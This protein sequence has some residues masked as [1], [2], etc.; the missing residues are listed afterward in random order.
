MFPYRQLYP[1]LVQSI[2]EAP[3]FDHYRL[4][5]PRNH[6]V[7]DCSHDTGEIIE[8]PGACYEVWN[9]QTPCINCSSKTCRALH[10]DMMKI[11]Y[12]D[13]RVILVMSVP[14]EV[15]GLPFALELVK[16]VTESFLVADVT[17]D[18]N[19]EI[20]TMIAKFNDMATRDAFTFLYNKNF[21]SNQIDE[22]IL[23]R[24]QHPERHS[25]SAPIFLEFD[26][27]DFKAVNDTYGHSIGDDV[28][29][30]VSKHVRIPIED[31]G[32]WTGRLGGDEFLV[33]LPEASL[34][35]A[36]TF[37]Q[38]IFQKIEKYVFDTPIGPFSVTVST[39]LTRLR[40]DDTRLTL[41]DR[42]D[43]AMY[44]AK[45]TPERWFESL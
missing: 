42:V 21:I 11:E 22:L 34:P 12:V 33:C 9:R 36:R 45:D 26:I 5:D 40:D 13:D 4:I 35:T 7:F 28:I 30:Y 18:D 25:A 38:N 43:R 27:D 10:I 15:E 8:I 31:L 19:T 3:L 37:C 16:D 44:A 1:P 14:V 24:K 41:L 2:L 32:G 20:T 29:L 23:D 17:V 39:G 6:H